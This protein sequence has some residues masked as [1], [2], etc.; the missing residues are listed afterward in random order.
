M[1]GKCNVCSKKSEVFAACSSCG[2]V[3]FSYCKECIDKGLEP[4][5]ALV[6]MGLYFD[7]ISENFV[8]QILLP[9]LKFYGKTPEEF[10]EDVKKFDDEYYDWLQ[11]QDDCVAYEY[12]IE[13]FGE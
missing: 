10:D 8:Q 2:G 13:Q 5:V 1:I 9:S 4:Y 12:D 3:S 11:H 7:E 6:G